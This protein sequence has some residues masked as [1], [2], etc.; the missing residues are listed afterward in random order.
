MEHSSKMCISDMSVYVTV[1][2]VNVP[3]YKTQEKCLLIFILKFPETICNLSGT[4]T[5]K[6][7]EIRYRI[8]FKTEKHLTSNN[9]PDECPSTK[10]QDR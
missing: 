7:K 2:V 8:F 5:L 1:S 4:H 3:T 10:C 6:R 9:S